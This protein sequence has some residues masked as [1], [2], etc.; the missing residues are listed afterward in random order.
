MS[1]SNKNVK[2]TWILVHKTLLICIWRNIRTYKGKAFYLGWRQIL[3][4]YGFK[5][6][7]KHPIPPIPMAYTLRTM[8]QNQSQRDTC[9]ICLLRK[10]R[11][12]YFFCDEEMNP[13]RE[14]SAQRCM[15]I[16]SKKT[17]NQHLSDTSK[18]RAGTLGI[19]GD[20]A[21]PV[22]Q[23][24]ISHV[25]LLGSLGFAS[26]NSGCRHGTTWHAMLW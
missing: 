7:H 10:A 13:E 25:P 5:I 26:S 23:Q 16:H 22:A 15:M 4:I 19:E 3:Y 18:G 9:L 21:S 24:L 6:S 12:T 1:W 20:G 14:W 8:S 17:K 2:C 11:V